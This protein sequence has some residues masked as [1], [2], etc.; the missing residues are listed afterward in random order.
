[1][2]SQNEI[3]EIKRHARLENQLT[4]DLNNDENFGDGEAIDDDLKK[5]LF[6][7]LTSDDKYKLNFEN[8]SKNVR[9]ANIHR[10]KTQTCVL[11]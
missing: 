5:E 11:S 8:T 1:M 3:D 4:L 2:I 10:T 6:N 9:I 7:S